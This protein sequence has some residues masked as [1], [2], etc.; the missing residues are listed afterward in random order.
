MIDDNLKGDKESILVSVKKII[1][2]DKND[3]NFNNDIIMDT[4]TVLGIL[5]QMGIGR[6]GVY[7]EDEHLKWSDFLTEKQIDLAAVKTWT[8]LKVKLIF[9]PP[10]SS[11]HLQSI[12][13]L[14]KEL[15]WRMYATENYT[16][17]DFKLH[18]YGEKDEDKDFKSIKQLGPYLYE[19]EYDKLDI[20]YSTKYFE[21]D[22]PYSVSGCSS[23][24]SGNFYGRNLD[25]IYGDSPEFVVHVQ[26]MCHK[27]L[28]ISGQI[29]GLTDDF[30]KSGKKSDLY[31]MV[32]F[33]MVDGINDAGIVCNTNVVPIQKGRTTG[34]IPTYGKENT[35]CSLQ[36]PLYILLNF[37]SA[38]AAVEY[39]KG[40]CS[41]YV[42]RAVQAMGYETH[43]MIADKDN[44]YCLEFINNRVEIVDITDKPFI[45]NFHLSGVRF[46][47]DGSVYTPVDVLDSKLPTEQNN[48]ESL[49]S[50]LERYNLINIHYSPYMIKQDMIRLMKKLIYTNAYR[51]ETEPFWYTEFV[52]ERGLTV[53]SI[54]EEYSDVVDIAIESFAN[55][56]RKGASIDTWQTNHMSVY[57]MESKCLYLI[58]QEYLD[59]VYEIAL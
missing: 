15:E 14:I 32:P 3:D 46:N 29:P 39:L 50:G 51:R 5:V 23:V 42:P 43:L 44:T 31:K 27:I 20:D 36:L 12:N 16:D 21:K 10:T 48:M 19:M 22:R 28:G 37:E 40:F 52:G 26:G 55:R 49:G 25:W 35:L 53:D 11:V 54:P 38:K 17:E 47:S 13:E 41:I 30:V 56:K 59:E 58:S 1:G 9:D 33:M 57:D 8:G 4:N 7:I 18:Y 34:T 6:K 45:T 24:R 2:I